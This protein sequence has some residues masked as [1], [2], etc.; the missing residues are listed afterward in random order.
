VLKALDEA[1]RP[2][3]NHLPNTLVL[4]FKEV[5]D[6][7]TKYAL[8]SESQTQRRIV[9]PHACLATFEPYRAPRRNAVASWVRADCL[10][11]IGKYVFKGSSVIES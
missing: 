5:S 10:R 4:A 1:P 6:G 3:L 7:G 9:F 2:R 11:Y 8:E